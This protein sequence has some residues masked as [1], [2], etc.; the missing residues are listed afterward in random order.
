M[1]Y[2]AGFASGAISAP[3][4]GRLM[5]QLGA[6]V[7]CHAYFLCTSL[8]CFLVSA[9]SFTVLVLGRVAGGIATTFLFSAFESWMVTHIHALGLDDSTW[10][11]KTILG[12][13]TL[14]SSAIAVASGIVSDALVS[15]SG[16]RTSP[17]L[18][19]SVCFS[20]ASMTLLRWDACEQTRSARARWHT[21]FGR[22]LMLALT[23]RR[24]LVLGIASCFLEGAMYLFVFFW[25]ASFNSVRQHLDAGD[26]LPLGLIFSSFMCS[27]TIGSILGSGTL[28]A[29]SGQRAARGLAIAMMVASG[30]LVCATVVGSEQ[31]LLWVFCTL[32]ASIGAYFPIMG[33]L[34]SQY[35]D[36]RDRSR[37]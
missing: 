31:L 1:L 13:M 36:D 16:G 8:S 10:H 24:I 18:A 37:V 33:F 30:S 21:D 5:D 9:D 26:E 29:R 22:S 32:E 2:A 15:I 20:V 19:A 27:M 6:E 4:A 14:M 35:V 34:K 17:F 28:Y 7:G 3:L 11:L 12:N 25:T 23:N